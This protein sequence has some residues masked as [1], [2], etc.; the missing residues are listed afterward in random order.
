MKSYFGNI[1]DEDSGCKKTNVTFGIIGKVFDPKSFSNRIGLNPTNSFNIGDTFKT[2]TGSIVKRP[3]S[4]WSITT[5]NECNSTNVNK[6]F[7]LIIKLLE[8]KMDII[9]N[10]MNDDGLRIYISVWWE[11]QDGHGGYS[12]QSDLI[13][14]V[15]N[16]CN[17][18]DFY[19]L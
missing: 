19:F 1:R 15:S 14:R 11:S 3:Y 4:L 2:K 5:E 17:E 13:N 6:H 16:L 10:Y 12:I 18:L 9:K 8:D 7:D